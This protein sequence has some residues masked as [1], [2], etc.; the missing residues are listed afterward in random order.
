MQIQERLQRT[1]RATQLSRVRV[2][3][4]INAT[5]GFQKKTDLKKQAALASREARALEKLALIGDAL[6]GCSRAIARAL[7]NLKIGH[8]P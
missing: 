1:A 3:R 7:T 5:H 4:V 6:K 8:R 2:A